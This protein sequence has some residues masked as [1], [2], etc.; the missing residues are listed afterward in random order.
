MS[1]RPIAQLT[2]SLALCAAMPLAVSARPITEVPLTPEGDSV[3]EE[4]TIDSQQRQ[5]AMVAE[6]DGE[7]R[8]REAFNADKGKVRLLMI[9]APT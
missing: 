7:A 4:A 3:T 1:H 2:T 8:L 5:A 9:L 6:I